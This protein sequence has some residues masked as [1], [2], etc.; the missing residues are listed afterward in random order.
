MGGNRLST[1]EVRGLNPL[2]GEIQIQGS[3]NAVLPIMAA[4]MLHKG[5]T[6]I[7][8]VPKIQD[9]NCMMGILEYMGCRCDLTGHTLTIDASQLTDTEIPEEYIKGMRSSIMMLGALLA[10]TG[11][12]V[13]Y[14]PGGCSIGSR[15]IDLHLHALKELGAEVIEQEDRIEAYCQKLVGKTI[16]FYYPSVG[17]TENALL[18]AVLAEGTT[19]ICGAAKEPEIEELCCF[20]NQMGADITG[21]G[22]DCLVIQGVAA[23]HDSQFEVSGDRIVAGTYLCAVSAVSGQVLLTGINPGYM[24]SVIDKF[25]EMGVQIECGKNELYVSVKDR[26][27]PIELKT[28]PYPGFPTDLQ[29]PLLAVLCTAG[30]KSKIIET[31][32]EGRYETA[33]ELKKL[34]ARIMIQ[35]S[36]AW[37]HGQ[38]LL[39][40]G[41]VK[42]PDLRGGAALVV[43]GLAAQ[44]RT[45]IT[46]CSH[47]LRGYEDIC[48]DLRMLGADI[49]RIS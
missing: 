7:T 45:E 27:K 37:V 26:V 12:A 35:D 38:A 33:N 4:S 3:K 15:P 31:V 9:V 19:T 2:K 39:T 30:G 8:H 29:S 20:L 34:G 16:H 25:R 10:R 28:E 36:C 6:V 13:T 43:A 46:G 24:S 1:I 18:G 48:K 49:R 17:A 23:L 41:R 22:T 32:F 44:G 11:K 21:A 47:I 5:T 40:G 14:H 42:A